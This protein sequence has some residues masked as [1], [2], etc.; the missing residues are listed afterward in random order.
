MSTAVKTKQWGNSIGIIIPK[1]L[2]NDLSIVPGEELSIEI[3]KK[4]N[5]LQELFGAIKLKRKTKEIL[6]DVRKDLEGELI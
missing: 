5:V 6:N 1:N 4:E 3:K 2:V